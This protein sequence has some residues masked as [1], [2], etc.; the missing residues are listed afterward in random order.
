MEIKARLAKI[1]KSIS[2]RARKW[3]KGDF[4]Q[5]PYN[6]IV[7]DF[8]DGKAEYPPKRGEICP[9]CGKPSSGRKP[10]LI[11]FGGTPDDD[12]RAQETGQP[13]NGR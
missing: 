4:C 13:S 2:G 9:K 8:G 10:G 1:E 7:V 6:F 3:G 11:I 5:C 12:G